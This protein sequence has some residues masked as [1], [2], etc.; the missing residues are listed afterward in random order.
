VKYERARPGE[1]AGYNALVSRA[2]NLVKRD[3]VVIAALVVLSAAAQALAAIYSDSRGSLLAL[4]GSALV[5][6]GWVALRFR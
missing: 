1:S 5:F 3:A 4:G 2:P 6:L